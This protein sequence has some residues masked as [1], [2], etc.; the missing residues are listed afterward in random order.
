MGRNDLLWL[1]LILNRQKLWKSQ[2][3]TTAVLGNQWKGKSLPKEQSDSKPIV[4]PDL[5]GFMGVLP[6][7]PRS[8]VGLPPLFDL[9][10]TK[11]TYN[12]SLASAPFV[13][14][15]LAAS[16]WASDPNSTK[17]H[18]TLRFFWFWRG[19]LTNF[20]SG[21]LPSFS[22]TSL[23]PAAVDTYISRQHHRNTDGA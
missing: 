22:R 19:I 14:V 3:S 17:A 7:F 16:H 15:S 1:L 20:I 13:K 5:F 18:R 9:T 23:S 6:R 10:P 12:S 2:I 11:S 21:W 8:W 4:F